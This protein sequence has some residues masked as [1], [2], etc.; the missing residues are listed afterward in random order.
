[1]ADGRCAAIRPAGRRS[2]LTIAL[3]FLTGA[4]AVPA[5]P[6]SSVQA[7]QSADPDP[8]YADREHLP[9]ALAAAAAW[10]SRLANNPLDFEAAWKLARACYW[11]GSHV[12]AKNRRQQYERGIAAGRRAI[13]IEVG[14]PEGHF[15]LAADMGALAETSGWRTGLKY[16]KAVKQELEIVLAIDPVYQEG[17]A[18]RALGRWYARVPGLFGGSRT[19]AVDHLRRSLTYDP[20]NA[21]SHYFLAETYLA[22]DRREDARREF[23]QVLDAPLR[24]EWIPEVKEFKEKA[25]AQLAKLRRPATSP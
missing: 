21:A 1:M 19:R 9:S 8:L 6:M 23:L 11:L 20:G 3:L 10:E 13:A 2:A 22:M 4:I 15:W 24:P 16:R 25:R 17:S 7:M 5:S 18:D 14:R 12:P